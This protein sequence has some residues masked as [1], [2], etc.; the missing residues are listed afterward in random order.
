MLF[1]RIFLVISFSPVTPDLSI[2]NHW[3]NQSDSD[4]TEGMTGAFEKT[5]LHNSENSRYSFIPCAKCSLLNP[6]TI[7]KKPVSLHSP[8][9]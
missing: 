6:L 3:A 8:I 1:L 9:Q 7:K 4:S 5:D 2:M